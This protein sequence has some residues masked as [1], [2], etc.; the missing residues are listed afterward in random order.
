MNTVPNR[1]AADERQ[2]RTKLKRVP[3][4]RGAETGSTKIDKGVVMRKSDKLHTVPFKALD[5]GA[6]RQTQ[7]N[8]LGDMAGEF[9]GFGRA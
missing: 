6:S 1:R 2:L 7:F 3:F 4:V 5:T 9:A 8:G